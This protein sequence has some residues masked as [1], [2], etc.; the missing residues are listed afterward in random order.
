MDIRYSRILFNE[1]LLSNNVEVPH[2]Y[3]IFSKSEN[4]ERRTIAAPFTLLKFKSFL[5]DK[6]GPQL[7]TPAK[8]LVTSLSSLD[9]SRIQTPLKARKKV[10]SNEDERPA[11]KVLVAEDNLLNSKLVVRMLTL[12]GHQVDAVFNG[13]EALEKL[14]LVKYDLVLMVRI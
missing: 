9:T 2:E 10:K 11:L 5:E 14:K 13:L 1:T 12:L 8:T 3:T 6:S 7:K 4:P